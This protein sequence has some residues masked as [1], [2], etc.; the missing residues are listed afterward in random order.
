MMPLHMLPITPSDHLADL[1]LFSS[2]LCGKN[3]YNS[4][5]MVISVQNFVNSFFSYLPAMFLI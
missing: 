2:M 4:T 3:N 1:F 5:K